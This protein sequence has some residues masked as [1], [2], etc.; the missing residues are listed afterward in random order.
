MPAIPNA[1]YPTGIVID[2]KS[3]QGN[4]FYLIGLAQSTYKGTWPVR[5]RNRRIQA[6]T[7]QRKNVQRTS[8]YFT[9]MV[10]A[11]VYLSLLLKVYFYTSL[12]IVFSDFIP[13]WSI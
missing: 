3:L 11:C 4:V 9:Q 10:R 6:G 2:L 13:I 7:S 12:H 1:K 5:R 8:R